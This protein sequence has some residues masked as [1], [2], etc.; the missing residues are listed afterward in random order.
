MKRAGS[1]PKN[2]VAYYTLC[3]AIAGEIETFGKSISIAGKFAPA[4]DIAIDAVNKA[5]AEWEKTS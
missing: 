1:P 3:D 4:C 2:Y 5:Q